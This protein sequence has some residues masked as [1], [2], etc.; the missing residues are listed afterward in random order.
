[1]FSWRMVL[2]PR[3][4]HRLGEADWMAMLGSFVLI[5]V[6]W[7]ESD[8]VWEKSTLRKKKHPFPDLDKLGGHFGPEKK[9]LA[10][11]P[12]NSQIRCRHLPAP[13]PLPFWRPPPSWDFH[14][15]IEPPPPPGASDSPF[16][17]PEQKKIKK[18]PKR[19]PSKRF[20]DTWRTSDYTLWV[21]LGTSCN[22][23]VV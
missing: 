6:I 11:P 17:L 15:K 4:C 1:M 12:P 7:S 20:K 9:Y 23:T 8:C 5:L 13:R 14:K 19:P 10:P 21:I 3:A 22:V 2:H 18:Y 16:R